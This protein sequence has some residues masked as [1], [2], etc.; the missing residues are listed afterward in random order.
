MA[1]ATGLSERVERLRATLEEPLLVSSGV[2]VRYLT[3]FSSSNAGLL[4]G[5]GSV[6][7][8]SDFR[9]A[10]A[11]RAV[12]GVEFVEIPRALFKSVAERL[13]GRIGFEADAVTYANY[14]LLRDAGIDLV[15]RRGL[16]ESLRAVKDEAELATIREACRISDATFAAMAAET[17]VGR[18]EQDLAWR[19]QQLFHENGADGLAFETI[20]GSGPTGAKPH[21]R[22]TDRVIEANTLVV[23]DAGCTVDG[24]NSDCTRT[25]ATGELP[26]DLAEIYDVCLRAQ[27]AGLEQMRAGTS[28]ADADAAA[29]EIIDAAGYGERFGHG[30]GHGIGLL[31]HEAPTARPESED[32]LEPGN[33]LSCEPGIY[34]PDHAGV[35]IEDLV[36]ITDGEPEILTSFTKELVTVS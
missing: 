23:I 27:L 5:E 19:M 18:T 30:L 13:E 10:T 8:F 3:G 21:G 17:F 6:Q 20:V 11:G 7:L 32:V 9:Y 35:R 26:D 16:V 31:V 25:F 4:V 22:P 33:V 36:V 12:P 15:P 2:N 1:V 34:I 14:E 28:G 24:Y 29:R